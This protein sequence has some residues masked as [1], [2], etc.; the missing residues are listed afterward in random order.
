VQKEVDILKLLLKAGADAG[1]QDK[2]SLRKE[3]NGRMQFN[4]ARNRSDLLLLWVSS[5]ALLQRGTT[6]LMKASGKGHVEAVKLLVAARGD[7]RMKNKVSR[8]VQ[9]S[10]Q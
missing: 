9:G 2:V 8:F 10:L 7:V 3:A 5:C 6:A 4:G 1:I